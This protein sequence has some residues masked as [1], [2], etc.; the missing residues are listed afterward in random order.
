[1]SVKMGVCLSRALRYV[2]LVLVVVCLIS[3][4]YFDVAGL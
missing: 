2:F 4:L 1:M 3:K